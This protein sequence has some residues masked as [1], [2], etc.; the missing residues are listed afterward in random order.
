MVAAVTAII[1][2]GFLSRP[3]VVHTLPPISSPKINYY[4]RYGAPGSTPLAQHT[5]TAVPFYL[6]H[7]GNTFDSRYVP[8]L[9]LPAHPVPFAGYRPHGPPVPYYPFASHFNGFGGL[10]NYVPYI[11]SAHAVPPH[12]HA[13]PPPVHAVPPPVHAV[14]PSVHVVPPPVS[15]PHY[16]FPRYGLPA[17]TISNHPL[18]SA[19]GVFDGMKYTTA[20]Y[21]PS[22]P[23][24]SDPI[25]YPIHGVTTSPSLSAPTQNFAVSSEIQAVSNPI[26]IVSYSAPNS[27]QGIYEQNIPIASTVQYG[28]PYHNPHVSFPDYIPSPAGSYVAPVPIY[29][30]PAPFQNIVYNN[31]PAPVSFAAPATNPTESYQ[32]IVPIYHRRPAPANTRH[33][34][35]PA[36]I[37]SAPPPFQFAAVS[38]TTPG[39]IYYLSAPTPTVPQDAPALHYTAPVANIPGPETNHPQYYYTPQIQHPIADPSFLQAPPLSYYDGQHFLD[40]KQLVYRTFDIVNLALREYR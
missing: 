38:K 12:V 5:P 3:A 27:N 29:H 17:A 23:Y 21:A 36:I 26:H 34:S 37:Y 32:H 39:I 4:I 1:S 6:P 31:N 9:P 24:S 2:S 25:S 35:A 10:T 18:T 30:R 20:N 40:Q 33:Q 15:P 7:Y 14:P 8:S 11:P 16:S 28:I 13:V 19:A 22:M